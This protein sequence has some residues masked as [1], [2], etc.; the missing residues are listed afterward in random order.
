MSESFVIDKNGNGSWVKEEAGHPQGYIVAGTDEILLN[1]KYTIPP[2]MVMAD[3]LLPKHV[4][5]HIQK[6]VST[7]VASGT[8]M[9]IEP[10]LTFYQLVDGKWTR[11][12]DSTS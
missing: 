6:S 2:L 7:A 8:P 4:I 5:E 12:H 1:S 9:V 10:G 3:R 11:I